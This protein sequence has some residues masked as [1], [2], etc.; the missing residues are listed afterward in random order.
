MDHVIDPTRLADL[1]AR[2][3]AVGCEL[4]QPPPGDSRGPLFARF[5]ATTRVFGSL[6]DAGA[7]LIQV[8]G[9]AVAQPSGRPAPSPDDAPSDLKAWST[10]RAQLALHKVMAFRSDPADGARSFFTLSNGVARAYPDQAALRA[11]L[12]DLDGGSL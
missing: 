8:G 5:G 6:D 1:R 9:Q 7:F 12:E 4:I 11:R 3:M 10:L 2:F